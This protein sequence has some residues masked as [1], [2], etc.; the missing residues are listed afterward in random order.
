MMDAMMD[1][2]PDVCLCLQVSQMSPT[3]QT[4]IRRNLLIPSTRGPGTLQEEEEEDTNPRI[5]LINYVWSHLLP[6]INS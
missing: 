5:G 6:F 3:E 2:E 1:P 4:W